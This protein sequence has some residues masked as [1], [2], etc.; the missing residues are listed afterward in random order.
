VKNGFT[1]A[2][3][4]ERTYI[5]CNRLLRCIAAVLLVLSLS[6]PFAAGQSDISVDRGVRLDPTTEGEGG[7]STSALPYFVMAIYTMVVLTIVCMPSR[8]A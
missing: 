8:K 7:S 4:R 2:P 1:A 3:V 6:L 5:M